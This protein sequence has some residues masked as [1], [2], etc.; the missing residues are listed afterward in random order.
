[1][2]GSEGFQLEPECALLCAQPLK[3]LPGLDHWPIVGPGKGLERVLIRRIT[4]DANEGVG[5]PGGPRVAHLRIGW[6]RCDRKNDLKIDAGCGGRSFQ[7][8]RHGD[9]D[10]VRA[11]VH[12]QALPG[13]GRVSEKLDSRRF[14][15]GYGIDGGN[16]PPAVEDGEAEDLEER[17]IAEQGLRFERLAFR[18]DID[19]TDEYPSRRSDFGYL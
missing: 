13:D 15:D 12:M 4:I 11:E 1:M 5:R 17:G 18:N 2:D 7:H 16:G 3:D 6:C 10:D 9:V 19:T 8:G 14:R